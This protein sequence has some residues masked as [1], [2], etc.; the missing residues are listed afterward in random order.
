M[1]TET[2]LPRCSGL[3]SAGVKAALIAL[4]VIAP[5]KVMADA[6]PAQASDTL[7]AKVSF[8]NVDFSTSQ[9][10]R[11]AYER[12]QDA[13]RHLCSRL[14]DMHPQS[15]AHHSGYIKC[16]DE[17][18]ARALPQMTAARLAANDKPAK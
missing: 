12:V 3:A 2:N 8:T 14:E 1:S 9:G 17:T 10:Q 11:I 18:I 5:I 15:L 13:A 4:C 7:A 6:P 16:V